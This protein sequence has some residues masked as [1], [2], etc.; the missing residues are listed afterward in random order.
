MRE[1]K[2]RYRLKQLD[3]KKGYE[4]WFEFYTIE[5][6]ESGGVQTTAEIISRDQYTG[7]K[8]K[9]GKE[10]Y[11]GDIFYTSYGCTFPIFIND[12]HGIRVYIGKDLMTLGEA[13]S[14]K[15]IGNI[16]ENP[17]LMEGKP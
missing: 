12:K 13:K 9:N 2:I 4:E 5:Q 1:I 16:Y 6:I 8:D 14:G 10:I 17:E 11:E 15:I 3:P 7:L